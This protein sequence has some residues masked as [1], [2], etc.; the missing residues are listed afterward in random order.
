MNAPSV[1]TLD[2]FFHSRSIAVIGVSGDA[3][4]IGHMIATNLLAAKSLDLYFVH[5]SR[6]TLLERPCYAD[7]AALP[8]APDLAV[9][10]L[11]ADKVGEA[12][13]SCGRRGIRHAIVIAAGFA[14]SG[15]RGARRQRDLVRTCQ[16]FGL[17]VIGP[18]TSGLFNCSDGHSASFA[19]AGPQG[20][21]PVSFVTQS[22]ST[23]MMLFEYGLDHGLR[24][25]KVVDCGNQADVKDFEVLEY[26]GADPETRVIGVFTEATTDATRF[27]AVARNLARAKPIVVAKVAR[28]PAGKRAARAHSASRPMDA[29]R[30][31]RA[32]LQNGMIYAERVLDVA[33]LVKTL[34]WQPLPRGNRVGIISAS[35]GVTVELADAC[36]ERG[37]RVPVLP[38]AVQRRIEGLMPNF[39]SRQNPI[40][41]GP[42]YSRFP[43]I[44]TG[45]LNALFDSQAVDSII[46]TVIDRG[47]SHLDALQAIRDTV[48]HR[49]AGHGDTKPVYVCW[50]SRREALSNQ[51]ILEDVEIPCFEQSERTARVAGAIADYARRRAA[52]GYS[53]R[54]G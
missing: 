14:E 46:V 10:A 36:V 1:K 34:A 44:Y 50:A 29:A 25:S 6:Q 9:I 23:V 35:G 7:V 41:T 20:G 27:F 32:C 15:G 4:K 22:G 52:G 37:L 3:G 33:D 54:F 2:P 21:G 30:F 17:R 38:R 39:A 12:L 11:P 43:E 28:T 24:F 16:T 40:D 49:R 42:T 45:C 18:N 47:A 51:R 53:R 8:I 26:L 31:R 5:R 19:F 48:Q 13:R